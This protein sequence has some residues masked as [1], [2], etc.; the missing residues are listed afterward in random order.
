MEYRRQTALRFWK[1]ALR[2][3]SGLFG[4]LLGLRPVELGG[5]LEIVNIDDEHSEVVVKVPEWCCEPGGGLRLS[6]ALAMVDEVSTYCGTCQWDRGLRAGVSIQLEANL[7]SNMD[8]IRAGDSFRIHT[9]LLKIGKTVGFVRVRGTTDAGKDVL[10]GM[11]VK[12]MPMGLAWDI[13]MHALVRPISLPLWDAYL[14]QKPVHAYKM[15]QTIDQI[16]SLNNFQFSKQSLRGT[17]SIVV[18]PAHGN[19]IGSIHGGAGV[20]LGALASSL[21]LNQQESD[22]IL[23]PMYIRTNLLNGIPTTKGLEATL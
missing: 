10:S 16:F 5:D 15:P 14:Q 2:S 11:H 7:Q 20:V 9:Q 21:A 4:T 18:T 23:R 12:Y 22:R 17:A 19:P 13:G 1:F 8:E 6:A 3:Q